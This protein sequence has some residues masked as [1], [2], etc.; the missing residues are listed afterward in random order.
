MTALAQIKIAAASITNSFVLCAP[1]LSQVKYAMIHNDT[2]KT[3]QLSML[4]TEPDVELNPEDSWVINT[5]EGET[6]GLYV[7][8]ETHAP[9]SGFVRI[10]RM[11]K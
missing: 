4:G 6:Y 1:V 9:N 7:R 5:P 8:Y 10:T 11:V 3:V 2:N